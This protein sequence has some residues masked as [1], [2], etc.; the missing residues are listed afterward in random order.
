MLEVL[1]A[2][3]LDRLTPNRRGGMASFSIAMA[4]LLVA[5]LVRLLL[6]PIEAGLPFLT[7]FP[8][9]TLAAVLGGF[10]AGIFALLLCSC[11]VSYLFFPPYQSLVWAFHKDIIWSNVIFYIEE[12][13]VILVAEAMYQQ[14]HR[15]RSMEVLLHQL[16]EAK[17]EQKIAAVAFEAQEG[18]MITDADGVILR[19]NQAFTELS[20]YAAEELVGQTPRML[21]S[22][23]H[24]ATFYRNMWK[25][26]SETGCWCG[27]IWDRRKDGELYLKWLT[28]AAVKDEAGEITHYV[29]TQT[30]ITERVAAAHQIEH[31]AFYDPLTQLPNRRLL[32][33]RVQQ[34]LAM[35]VH[36]CKKGALLFIDLDHFKNI[37][38]TFGHGTGDL[39]LQQVAERLRSCVTEVDTVARIGG[40]EFVILLEDLSE[41]VLEAAKGVE[42]VA[43]AMLLVLGVPYQI[44]DCE[45]HSSVSMGVTMFGDA[46]ISQ[47][48]LF[49]QADIAMYQAKKAGRNALKFF[50][51][52]MQRVLDERTV[53]EA[54]LYQAVEKQQFQ[55]YYQIQCDENGHPLGAEA[56]IRWIHPEQGMISP[57]KFIP[58][59]EESDLILVMGKW[60]L[61]TACAQLHE[62]QHRLSMRHFKLAINVS[63]KQLCQPNFVDEV[64]DALVQ[65]AVNPALLKL[66]ITESMFVDNVACLIAKMNTL[67]ALGIRFSM[68]DFGTGYSSLQYLK[69][70]PLTQLKIDQAFVRDLVNDPNDKAIVRT[71]IG[72]AQSMELNLIA[73]GVETAAQRDLLLTMGCQQFQGYLFG[74]PMPIAEFDALIQRL[75]VR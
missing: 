48:V 35:S 42:H 70:L 18:V 44:G 12:L 66:E 64:R 39:L 51:P 28:I 50:D 45:H 10:R 6:A 74:K 56:L 21:K 68:D 49:K 60:V 47:E 69:R 52:Q 23:R 1:A 33:D 5:L 65:Y 67:G 34:A 73:E 62:W 19:V 72:M 63:V 16:E 20:G 29:S 40:D 32:F 38:D 75:P 36:S 15:S 57:V 8:A 41:S 58:L 22:G 24:D 7:F 31:L 4:L 13:I 9:V 25:I 37:N 43:E 61:E 26:I 54:E 53:L 46:E 3:L 11:L 30:D 2:S 59:A 14:Q 71:I 17:Q 27:E 55:L